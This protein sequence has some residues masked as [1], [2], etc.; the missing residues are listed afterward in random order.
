MRLLALRCVAL[1]LEMYTHKIAAVSIT[2]MLTG[3]KQAKLANGLREMTAN[4]TRRL[5]YV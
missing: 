5:L 1:V 2:S 3:G 4:V